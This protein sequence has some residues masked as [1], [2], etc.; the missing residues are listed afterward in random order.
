MSD[1]GFDLAEIERSLGGHSVFAPS[2]ST[3]WLWCSGSLIPNLLAHDS[4]GEDAAYGTVGHSV[5]ETWLKSGERPDHLVGNIEYIEEADDIFAITIDKVM[6]DYVEQY[7]DWCV[8]LDG[9]HY[10]EQR[11]YFSRLTPIKKQG[12]TADHFVLSPGLMVITDLKMGK[13]VQVYAADNLD[14][15]RAF[16]GELDDIDAIRLNGNTQALLYAL[17]VFF[18][19]DA[20]Y[21]FEKICIRIAQPRLDHF[22]EWWTTREELLRFAEYVKIRAT[23]AW[24]LN[25]P[26]RA[27]PKACLWCR[28][29]P[30]CPA[31]VKMMNDMVDDCFDDL[32]AEVGETEMREA[33]DR[34]ESY[35]MV[36]LTNPGNLTTEQMSKVYLFRSLFEK[37]FADMERELE[38]R[39]NEGAKVPLHKL[40][41]S[42]SN[43]VWNDEKQAVEIV[44]EQGIS[45]LELYNLKMMSPAQAE[46]LLVA[47][48]IKRA[49]AKKIIA[50]AAVKP[51]GKPTL[52]PETDKRPA[53]VDPADECFDDLTDDDL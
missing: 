8:M 34:L 38:S 32:T 6:L 10:V 52:V 4:A 9:D 36:S 2:A 25:A 27:S 21:H 28:V 48:D 24:K 11:V 51:P 22:D 15:P 17:G 26:R 18:K 53:L 12:G 5:G 37:W 19:F 23:A 30:S 14:D 44:E 7:V 31:Y 45:S 13:G 1:L 29:K 41:E 33:I 43:R 35:E 16:I 20:Q 47:H 49:E 40:V 3:M 39:A 42:R 50:R 46:D